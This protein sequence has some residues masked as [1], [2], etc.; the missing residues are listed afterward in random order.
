MKGIIGFLF[1]MSILACIHAQNV[2]NPYQNYTDPP[3]YPPIGSGLPFTVYNLHP[4]H[5]D[6][7]INGWTG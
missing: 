1:N 3:V 4:D 7:M 2:I 6:N 5:V